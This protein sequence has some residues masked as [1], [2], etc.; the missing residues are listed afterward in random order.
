MIKI[1]LAVTKIMGIKNN[2]RRSTLFLNPNAMGNL[3][4]SRL[5]TR[6]I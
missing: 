2:T 3:I 6:T 1:F 4:S 5:D